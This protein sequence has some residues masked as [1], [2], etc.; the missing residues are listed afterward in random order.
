MPTKK[1]DDY[2]AKKDAM[3]TKYYLIPKVYSKKF[4]FLQKGPADS[5]T[6][7]M[8]HPYVPYSGSEL[9]D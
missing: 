2:E 9:K 8:S 6:D 4:R 1:N 3:I 5:H 7:V